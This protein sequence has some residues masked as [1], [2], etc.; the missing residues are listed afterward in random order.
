MIC[1]W[2]RTA[3][4]I[5]MLFALGSCGEVAFKR[6]S[7]PDAFAAARATC[8]DQNPEP[9]AEHACLS[10]AGWHVTSLGAEPAAVASPPTENPASPGVAPAVP[11]PAVVSVPPAPPPAPPV[12]KIAVGSWWKFGAGDADLHAAADACAA[13]L[14]PGDQ[15]APGYHVVTRALYACL[16]SHGWHGLGQSPS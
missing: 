2:S 4:P 1:A 11:G 6:G 15:P 10:Q 7:G 8:R 12:G 14:G 16:R 5:V 3:I 9:A 13:G